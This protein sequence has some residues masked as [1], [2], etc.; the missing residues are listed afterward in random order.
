MPPSVSKGRY[1]ETL[2]PPAPTHPHHRDAHTISSPSAQ[3][4]CVFFLKTYVPFA[5]PDAR[6][7][8]ITSDIDTM[9]GSYVTTARTWAAY[10]P[11]E[12]DG[13]G[14]RFFKYKGMSIDA[15]TESIGS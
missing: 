12:T 2:P 14:V 7:G 5:V 6:N 10:L 11:A 8:Q 13:G 9:F 4:A 15:V 3:N 1:V